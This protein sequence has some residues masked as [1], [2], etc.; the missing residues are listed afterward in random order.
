MRK[1][2]VRDTAIVL[3]LTKQD[4]KAL[5][6]RLKQSTGIKK[7]KQLEAVEEKL[8]VAMGEI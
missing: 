6:N 2:T 4:A 5:K 1:F 3:V 8:A 7:T